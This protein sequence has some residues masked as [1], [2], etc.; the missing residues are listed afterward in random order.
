[1]ACGKLPFTRSGLLTVNRFASAGIPELTETRPN[2]LASPRTFALES[3]AP[4]RVSAA[5]A[6]S[7][8][9]AVRDGRD[10]P[11][12]AVAA[13]V[14]VV[15]RGERDMARGSRSVGGSCFDAPTLAH[16]SALGEALRMVAFGVPA[17]ALDGSPGGRR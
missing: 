5:A 3:A 9:A 11:A 10:H 14:V 2:S 1:M 15:V 4:S 8:T 6:D 7:R 13:A 12:A 17:S 16:R